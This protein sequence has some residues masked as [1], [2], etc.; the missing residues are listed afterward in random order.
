[1]F[2]FVK[3]HFGF[4]KKHKKSIEILTDLCYNIKRILLPKGGKSVS[5]SRFQPVCSEYMF[6]AQ[7]FIKNVAPPEDIWAEGGLFRD[8]MGRIVIL[9]RK[10]GDGVYALAEVDLDTLGACS[11][12]KDG[13]EKDIFE[14]D[15]IRISHFRRELPPMETPENQEEAPAADEFVPEDFGE[16]E[17]PRIKREIFS[18]M[19]EGAEEVFTFCGVVFLSG[20]VFCVQFFDENTGMLGS[21]PLYMYFGFDGLPAEGAAVKVIGNL[22]DDEQLYSDVLHLNGG[23]DNN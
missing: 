7:L 17:L 16:N 8:D 21:A 6:R 20:N 15:I 2:Y 19:P 18:E 23:A 13:C 5:L 12:Y 9:N 1:M 10:A 4:Y 22:Y 14:G 3:G 11:G